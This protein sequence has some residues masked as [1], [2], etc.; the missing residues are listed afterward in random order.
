MP[1][2]NAPFVCPCG[3]SHFHRLVQF[4][5]FCCELE[6]DPDTAPKMIQCATCGRWYEQTPDWHW[7]ETADRSVEYLKWLKLKGK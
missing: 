3:G 2:N 6:T 4:N 5:A 7:V 1:D